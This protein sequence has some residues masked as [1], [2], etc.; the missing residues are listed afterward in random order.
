MSRRL[1]PKSYVYI[2]KDSLQSI[3]ITRAFMY[4]KADYDVCGF[5]EVIYNRQK[6]R[7]IFLIREGGYSWSYYPPASCF[8]QTYFNTR[9]LK[10]FT[11]KIM[12]VYGF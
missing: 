9:L 4:D 2:P 12:N 7:D 8:K 1:P 6:E 10:L 11:E 5:A 3:E